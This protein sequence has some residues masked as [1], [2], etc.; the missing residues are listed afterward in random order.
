[1]SF[2]FMNIKRLIFAHPRVNVIIFMNLT[3][4]SAVV[5]IMLQC[6]YDIKSQ[7]EF[8]Y[9]DRSAKIYQIQVDQELS[10]FVESDLHN[11][12]SLYDIGLRLYN[13]INTTELKTF[14]TN[15]IAIS[16][17]GFDDETQRKVNKVINSSVIDAYGFSDYALEGM[18]LELSE[19]RWF[20]STEFNNTN[21]IEMVPLIMGNNFA[22]VFC[23]GDIIIYEA[24]SIK[25]KAIVI[26]F[27]SE[28]TNIEYY[29]VGQGSFDDA[30]I[31][32]ETARFPRT[33]ANYLSD[34]AINRERV[35]TLT[36]GYLYC[37]NEEIDVQ[38]EINRHISQ[39]GFYP[40][41]VKPVDGIS[42]S[43]IGTIQKRNVFL[44]GVL[45]IVTT[46]IC[47][48]S[49]CGTLYNRT[50]DEL[51]IT[52]I[53]MSV[54][55]PLWKIN[56]SLIL[57][58]LLWIAL[59]IIPLLSFFIREFKTIMVPGWQI[60]LYE[61]IIVTVA[62]APSITFNN[63]CCIDYLIRNHQN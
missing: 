50:L 17:E 45:A 37:P 61:G 63:K 53:Y 59:S 40:L 13:E 48:A 6:F 62:L 9:Y 41:E 7:N 18:G 14:N 29:G 42:I 32:T 20:T 5:F 26:G 56:L 46:F 21:D 27:L 33:E 60:V 35:R 16:T 24:G 38:K 34:E 52:C 22:E 8:Y 23:V 3:L 28:H 58:M 30:I 4:T 2:Y 47:V 36:S 39:Y 57:E 11:K 54:G 10:G 49:L 51:R 15:A 43:E 25:D 1:M 31:M 19:G 12:T 44:V 55:V